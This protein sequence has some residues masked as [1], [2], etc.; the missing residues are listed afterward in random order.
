MTL[1]I[2][3]KEFLEGNFDSAYIDKKEDTQDFLIHY[4]DVYGKESSQELPLLSMEWAKDKSIALKHPKDNDNNLSIP[5]DYFPNV[6]NELSDTDK[7]MG[8]IKDDLFNYTIIVKKSEN[9]YLA[10]RVDVEY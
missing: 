8:V 6:I 3:M 7:L 5:I 1:N 4:T 10:F 9:D 2:D